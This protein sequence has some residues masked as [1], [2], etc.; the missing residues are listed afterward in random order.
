MAKAIKDQLV[1]A[2]LIAT[3]GFMI[4]DTEHSHALASLMPLAHNRIFG[5][6]TKGMRLRNG[7]LQMLYNSSRML[8]KSMPL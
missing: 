4:K 3:V 2:T 6:R 1:L 5:L 7:Y 8:R